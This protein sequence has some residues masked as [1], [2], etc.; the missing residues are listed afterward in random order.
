MNNNFLKVLLAD[1]DEDDR[2]LFGEAIKQLSIK[3]KLSLFR[4]GQE[5]MDYLFLNE[6]ERPNLLFLDLNM[7]VKN[8]MQCLREIRQNLA[9]NDLA[10]AIY[11]TSS[12][13]QDIED[14]FIYGANIYINK[15]SSFAKLK[16]VIEKV[17]QINWQYHTSNMNRNTF[18]FRF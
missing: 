17:L 8:G 2:F 5:L 9:F 4:D 16:E 1:D 6:I 15:P 3:T 10:I 7:P 13:E 18:L 12:T 11:S 14:T